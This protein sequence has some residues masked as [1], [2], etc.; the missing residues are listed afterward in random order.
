MFLNNKHPWEICGKLPE[1]ANSLAVPWDC[2]DR[3]SLR[4][5]L[6]THIT[7]EYRMV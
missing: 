7:R 6:D 5:R 2:C 4:D 1:I 3:D